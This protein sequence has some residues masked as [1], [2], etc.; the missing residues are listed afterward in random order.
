MNA[1]WHRV[2]LAANIIMFCLPALLRLYN[3]HLYIHTYYL[4]TNENENVAV[5]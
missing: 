4:V 2:W 3:V 5:N 1:H